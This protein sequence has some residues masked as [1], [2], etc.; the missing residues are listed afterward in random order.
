MLGIGSASGSL[1]RAPLRLPAPELLLSIDA[2]NDACGECLLLRHETRTLSVRKWPV[3]DL[4][5]SERVILLRSE[6]SCRCCV[7]G[8]HITQRV[9]GLCRAALRQAVHLR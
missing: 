3:R 7:P 4:Q 1:P 6:S 9:G 2:E 8:P 5:Q